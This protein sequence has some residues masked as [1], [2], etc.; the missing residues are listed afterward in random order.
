M[1]QT[2]HP[3]A[4][5]HAAARCIS[6]GPVYITDEPEKH[7]I[8]LLN[9]MTAPTVQDNTVILRPSVVGRTIDVYNDYNEGQILRIGSYT[10]WAKTGSGIIG[11]FNLKSTE[12]TCIVSLLDFP[13]IHNDTDGQYIVRAHTSGKVIERTYCFDDNSLVSV[14]LQDKGWEILTAYPTYSFSLKG[15]T[16]NHSTTSVGTLT[17]VAVLGLLG[18][19]TGAA[20][21]VSSDIFLVENGRLR[22]DIHLKALG[23]LGVYFSNLVD[24]DIGRDFMV[25]ILGRAIPPKTV[26]KIGGEN[27]NVLAIDVLAAWKAMKLDSGWSNEVVVQV[28]VG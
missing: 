13:G 7:D 15:S 23:T 9:Q 12:A 20:A 28:F 8:D 3:Y 14:I 10:G 11:L 1:F 17:N 2:Q 16:K 18:K 5:Y 19:M 27:A 25:M 24:L 22:F 21:V 4:S 6:G 26:W